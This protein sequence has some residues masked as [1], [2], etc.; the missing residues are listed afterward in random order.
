MIFSCGLY[1]NQT[2]FKLF[3][4]S[5]QLDMSVLKIVP[6]NYKNLCQLCSTRFCSKECEASYFVNRLISKVT[7]I[8]EKFKEW[9]VVF[10]TVMANSLSDS[11]VSC[12]KTC[13]KDNV[14]NMCL[15]CQSI[16]YN[17]IVETQ[18]W[19]KENHIVLWNYLI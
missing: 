11:V 15:K 17:K 9:N 16:H 12:P 1:F 19:A 7:I 3:S 13:S 8:N 5:F 10:D 14:S 2:L 18:V 4:N 6:S